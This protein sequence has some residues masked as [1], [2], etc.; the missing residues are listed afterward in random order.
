MNKHWEDNTDW[1]KPNY[2]EK[3][4]S[5]CRPAHH[6]SQVDWPETE[7]RLRAET[8]T[9]SVRVTAPPALNDI[10]QVIRKELDTVRYVFGTSTN[11]GEFLGDGT[12]GGGG[13][14][15]R[16]N[17]ITIRTHSR[18]QVSNVAVTVRT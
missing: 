2:S 17:R 13:A 18:D 11:G 6:E 14:R 1:E 8:D 16:T 12:E 4:L 15:A 10:G 9:P 5:P 3:T 7:N